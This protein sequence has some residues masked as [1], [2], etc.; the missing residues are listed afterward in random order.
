MRHQSSGIGFKRAAHCLSGDVLGLMPNSC[1]F[2]LPSLMQ[3]DAGNV[4][5][6]F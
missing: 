3:G 4:V 5:M 2:C 6:D 1:G